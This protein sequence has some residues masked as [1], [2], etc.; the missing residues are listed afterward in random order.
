MKGY[1]IIIRTTWCYCGVQRANFSSAG[2]FFWKCTTGQV[3]VEVIQGQ[4][5]KLQQT[6]SRRIKNGLDPEDLCNVTDFVDMMDSDD[7]GP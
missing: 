6:A 7:D 4:H 2:D 5:G 3:Q 1:I